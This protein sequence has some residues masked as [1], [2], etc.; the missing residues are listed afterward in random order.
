MANH[1][2]LDMTCITHTVDSPSSCPTFRPSREAKVGNTV[3][4]LHSFRKQ[5][6]K[7]NKKDLDVAKNRLKAV[8]ERLREKT[9]NETKSD[10]K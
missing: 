5:S 1:E 4:V 9:K 3:H 2:S 7:T 10:D 8:K 6:A